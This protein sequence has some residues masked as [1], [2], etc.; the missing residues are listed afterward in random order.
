MINVRDA[1]PNGYKG[2]SYLFR[3]EEILSLMGRQSAVWAW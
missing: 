2:P 3:W 1:W